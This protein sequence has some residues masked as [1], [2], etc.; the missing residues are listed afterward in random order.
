M[1]EQILA[2]PQRVQRAILILRGRRV[3]LD[4]DLAALYGVRVKRLNEQVKRNAARF[5]EDFVFRLTP[6]EF[7]GLRSQFATTK[8]ERRGGRQSLPY[9]FTEHGALM[10]ASV[11]SSPKAVAMS[12]L[13]VRAFVRLRHLLAA[14]HQLATKLG[15]L[16]RRIATHDK[17]IAALFDPVPSLM[18]IPVEPVRPIGFQARD[19]TK[20]RLGRQS[21]PSL[22]SWRSAPRPRRR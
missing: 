19:T 14:N 9:A 4:S 5:P 13:V 3:I 15:E 10:A 20:A 1:A 17:N 8:T 11:L 21:P 22:P 7:A 2:T 12:I 18:A 16:E 6:G